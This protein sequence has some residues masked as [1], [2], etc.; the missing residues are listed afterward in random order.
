MKIKKI[1]KDEE[2]IKILKILDLVINIE[3]YEKT[4]NYFKVK[5]D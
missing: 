5:H 3:V 1:F 4:Y 2:S